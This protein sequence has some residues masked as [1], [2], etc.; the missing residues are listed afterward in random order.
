MRIDGRIVRVEEAEIE[1][2]KKKHSIEVLVDRFSLRPNLGHRLAES[3][4]TACSL[5]GGMVIVAEENGPETL[6][7]TE[8]ACPNDGF[9]LTELEPR[10]FSFNSPHGAC[11]KCMGL[12]SIMKMDPDLVIPDPNLSIAGGAIQAPGFKNAG[13][14]GTYLSA[15]AKAY[16]FSLKT[17]WKKLSPGIR[18]IILNGTDREINMH[19]KGPKFSVKHKARFEGVLAILNRRMNQT[20][21]DSARF[22][23]QKFLVRKACDACG[24][25][26]LRPEAM[27]VTIGGKN[28]VQVSSMPAGESLK[29]LGTLK[30]P[31]VSKKIVKPI[32]REITARLGF[33]T[34]VGVGYLSLDR[35][36]GTLSGGE[37]QRIRLA[38]QIGSALAGVLYVLD[39]PTIGLHQRDNAR[40]LSTLKDLRDTGNTV[41]V[42]E[43]DEETIRSADTVVDMGPG[44]G[45]NG[46]L[47]LHCGTVKE[48]LEHKTSLT[49]KY[50]RGE[51]S[52]TLGRSSIKPG[53]QWITVHKARRNNLANID[54]SFPHGL[55]TCLTGVS[56]SG[57]SSLLNDILYVQ[58]AH[59]LNRVQASSRDCDSVTGFEGLDRVVDV[60]QSPIGRTPRSNPATYTGVFGL[61]RE[62]F[63][64]TLESKTRG[65][66]PGRFSF[67]V[68]GGRCSA[69]AGDG[70]LRID[71]HFLPSVYVTCDECS[72]KRYNP[73][74]LT[75]R[76]KGFDISEV[77]NMSVDQAFEVFENIPKLRAML[78]CLIDVGLGYVKLGQNSMTLSGGEA[79][80]IKLARELSRPARGKTLYILD[81]P[82][83][84]LHFSD[85]DNLLRV[86]GR[87][88]GMGH[89]VIVIEHN[90]DVIAHAD[91]IIDLGPDGGPD[92][93]TVVASG[94]PR[95]IAS[96][97]ASH[98]GKWLKKY[99]K[100]HNVT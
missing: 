84:G 15:V 28:I 66:K 64:G 49:S 10:L 70:V 47:V 17:P 30:F 61:V 35:K 65:Y 78:Q 74:T 16:D 1:D 42:V 27:A 51:R 93:G 92:G 60:N 24:G 13:W 23:Y 69:C 83:T 72:G 82:T 2:E 45:D 91:W 25:A 44:A 57:K 14:I 37:S 29:W 88:S 58:A 18:D 63:A 40:L 48:L 43:H 12:G 34:K 90:L 53:R 81:E 86:L 26:R 80:R 50:L 71:M 8:M 7:G 22:Y 4:E 3:F 67:N 9:T 95:E 89:T 39:E 56:G 99:F 76:Y 100:T 68:K 6:H 52:V 11:P 98:T 38:T 54:V 5:S 75:V 21:S 31:G 59:E 32:M 20:R 94:T 73:D 19:Y 55:F 77:L 79:Q 62:L 96:N 41:L 87:L 46:G 33:L 36:S 97:S 85:V